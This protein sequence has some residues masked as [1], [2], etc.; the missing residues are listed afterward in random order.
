[1]PT[2]HWIGKDKVINHHLDVPFK[3]L[4]H[5]YGFTHG[6][7]SPSETNSGNKIIHGDNLEALK[8]LLPEYEGRIKCIYIDPPYNTG[9]ESWVYNDNVND[10]KIKRWLGQV[11][12]KEAEDLT[13]HD[14]WLCMMYPRLKLLHKLLADDGAIFISIDDNEQANLK[15]ICDEIFGSGNFINNIIWQKKYSPQN[16]ARYLSDMHDFIICYAKSKS[17]W[18]RNL[19]PRKEEQNARYK[20]A[21]NDLRGNWKSSDLSVKTYN[22]NT[23]Y[24]ITT[25]SGRI[26]N[27][28]A[29]YCWRVSK[30][31]F[32]ELLL[33]N[34][35]WFGK[36]GS[37]V[38]S[39]KRFLSDVQDGTVPVT[40]WLRDE[41]GD[42]QEGKQELKKIFSES[43][44]P[45]ETPKP[46]R[47]LE[48]IFQI[49]SNPNDIIL[50]SFAGSGTTAHAV[51][52]LNKQDGGN[53][54]VI[55]IE[56]E[57]YAETITA[58]RVKRVIHGYGTTEGTG[59][60]FDYFTL[61]NALFT[62]GGYL[63]ETIGIEK[64]RQ[65][66]FYT[67][68]KMPIKESVE[69]DNPHFMGQ[70]NDTSY[71]FYYEAHG[72]TTLDHT[73]LATMTI[74]AEQY[75]IY[76]DNC[77]LTKEYMVKHNIIFKKIPRDISRF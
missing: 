12:G 48:K 40:L 16:D 76:A 18:N 37:N 8:A 55:L 56:M 9:N 77:L 70:N 25:P 7:Q 43:S 58:E 14:K 20:N 26:V 54:K 28:P 24:P 22:A 19:A 66:V 36:D 32:E 1:M 13:R 38:P 67:E 53:R 59:G 5:R 71:Y 2:L 31:K 35:I 34:R 64:L 61:G 41:V 33:E 15:L 30:D 6:V 68:T 62:E 65:Y 49:S 23:D 74:K 42:N 50:D 73:F 44:T 75:V 69:K 46:P 39:L 60:S 29:G 21:D 11:V 52:N 47:L 72:L 3:T 51:F 10:P 57:D 17:Q 63:N 4:E 45:F 27:P